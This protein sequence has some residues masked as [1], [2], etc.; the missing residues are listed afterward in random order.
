MPHTTRRQRPLA[1]LLALATL[2]GVTTGWSQPTTAGHRMAS[3]SVPASAPA[4]RPFDDLALRLDRAAALSTVPHHV[5]GMVAAGLVINA[6]LREQERQAEIAAQA[7]A[8]AAKQAAAAKAAAK[9]AAAAKAAA[10]VKSTTTTT[11]TGRNHFWIPSLRMSYP[12]YSYACGRTTRPANLI[13]RWGCGG[14]NNVY[15]LGHAYGVMKPLHDLYVRGGLRVGMVAVYA[16]ANGR[17]RKYR[18]TAWQVVYPTAVAWA[19]ADQPVPSMTLQ[20]CVGANS[21]KRLDVRLVAIN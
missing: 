9:Q 15:L 11:Y 1:T 19:I 12:V 20:T 7:A 2:L 16:D 21:E 13:Y 6:Q 14:R 17:V 8:A 18:V 4:F 5:L 3:L 10:T